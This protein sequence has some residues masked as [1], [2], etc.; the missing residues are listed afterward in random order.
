MKDTRNGECEQGYLFPSFLTFKGLQQKVQHR[1]I[2]SQTGH[3]QQLQCPVL[4][5][6]RFRASSE[7]LV[8]VKDANGSLGQS[9]S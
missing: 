9:N 7:E 1:V 8:R 2:P 5:T 3:R 6:Q 4:A